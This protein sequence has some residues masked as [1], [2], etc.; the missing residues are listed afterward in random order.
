M[1]E[2]KSRWKWYLAAGGLLIVLISLGYT[3]YVTSQ[4]AAEERHKVQHWLMA[5]ESI[6]KPLP[7]ECDPC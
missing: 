2:N 6:A 7:M 4:L 3:N 5:Q 1:Y